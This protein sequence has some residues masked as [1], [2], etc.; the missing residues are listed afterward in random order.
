MSGRILDFDEQRLKKSL[1][2][3]YQLQITNCLPEE[4]MPRVMEKLDLDED[5]AIILLRNLI[6]L[7][8]VST[9]NIRPRFFLRPGY[10]TFFPVIVSAA[11]KEK[12]E[13]MLV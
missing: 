9:G 2:Q 12:I 5:G 10:V 8:W 11:G 3:I 7:G 4:M 1:C 6:N 13:G